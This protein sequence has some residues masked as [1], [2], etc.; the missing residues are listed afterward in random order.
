MA[1]NPPGKGFTAILSRRNRQATAGGYPQAM[2]I[3]ILLAAAALAQNCPAGHTPVMTGNA[4]QPWACQWN[5]CPAGHMP[6]PSGNAFRPYACI[7]TAAAGQ[8]QCS[9]DYQA[10]ATGDPARPYVC[11]WNPCRYGYRPVPTGN[12]FQP[13]KCVVD[14]RRQQEQARARAVQSQTQAGVDAAMALM[15]QALR[16]ANRPGRQGQARPKN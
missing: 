2:N 1:V 7:R 16:Q 6:K 8:P 10:Y 4:A 9:L 5:P 13:Y 15:Q 14:A 11:E 12:A 3:L